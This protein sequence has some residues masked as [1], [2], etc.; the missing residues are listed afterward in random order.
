MPTRRSRP[1]STRAT[2]PERH[3]NEGGSMADE[4]RQRTRVIETPAAAAP[5][6]AADTVPRLAVG[7]ELIGEYED[8]GF[9]K[10]PYIARRED[11]Q[12]IQMPELLFRV[13][14][15]VDGTRTYAEIGEHVSA[16]V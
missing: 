2:K 10:A 9:K 5:G 11:G 13:A 4:Y 15:A 12:V 1:R 6:P 14:Q 16:Q 7:I 3:G 8:S